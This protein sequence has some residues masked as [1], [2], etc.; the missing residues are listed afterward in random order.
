MI[1]HVDGG[2]ERT[3]YF[4]SPEREVDRRQARRGRP[5]EEVQRW[6]FAT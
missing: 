2:S 5:I 1:R 3:A 4:V 6:L